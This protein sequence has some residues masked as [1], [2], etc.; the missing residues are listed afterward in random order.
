MTICDQRCYKATLGLPG[1]ATPDAVRKAY[2]KQVSKTH[3]DKTSPGASAQDSQEFRKY[4]AAYEIL[5]NKREAGP[6]ECTCHTL[7][8][9]PPSHDSDEPD[10][11]TPDNDRWL[12]IHVRKDLSLSELFAGCM[13]NVGFDVWVECY[14]CRGSGLFTSPFLKDCRRC[15]GTGN[16][17]VG[18]W[19]RTCRDCQG[20]GTTNLAECYMCWGH[21][22]RLETKYVNVRIPPRTAPGTVFK[23]PGAG[24]LADD[25]TRSGNLL[26]MIRH[27]YWWDRRGQFLHE[28]HVEIDIILDCL[29]AALGGPTDLDILGVT[30]NVNIP[31]RVYPGQW[32]TVQGEGLRMPNGEVGDLRLFINEFANNSPLDKRTREA[33]QAV[34][35]KERKRQP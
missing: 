5:S 13:A 26:V 6:S 34:L 24:Y 9:T 7:N 4:R 17:G 29:A 12:D 3:P 11:Q 18:R 16:T 8:A 14:T 25:S 19:A 28:S 22:R 2:R 35:A 21:K 10:E 23:V 15:Y 1:D 27:A 32:I 33:L 31:S 30:V 20:T